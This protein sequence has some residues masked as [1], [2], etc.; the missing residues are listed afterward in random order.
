MQPDTDTTRNATHSLNTQITI[1]FKHPPALNKIM[2]AA[3]YISTCAVRKD[4]QLRVKYSKYPHKNTRHADATQ[5]HARPD[6]SRVGTTRL[7]D[8]IGGHV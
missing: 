7:R 2:R 8:S 3:Q 6:R 1:Y 5:E 4:N